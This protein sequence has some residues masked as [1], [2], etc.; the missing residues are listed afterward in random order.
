VPRSWNYSRGQLLE[1]LL[2]AKERGAVHWAD[3]AEH[4]GYADTFKFR[5]AQGFNTNSEDVRAKFF[6]ATM[7]D[8]LRHG[9]NTTKGSASPYKAFGGVLKPVERDGNGDIVYHF[10]HERAGK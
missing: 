10:D 2:I 1:A 5:R 7:K 6:N 9:W 4:L 8:Y 3:I